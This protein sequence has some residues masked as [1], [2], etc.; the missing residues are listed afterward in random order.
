MTIREQLIQ[1]IEQAP[2]ALIEEILNFCLFVKQ[3]QQA[4]AT[5]QVISSEPQT[6]GILTFLEQV[7]EIQAQV[8][9]E[10]WDK[11]PHDGAINHDHYLYGAP[12]VDE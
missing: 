12:K 8:P 9:S 5:I 4:K 1:E 3:R 6:N 11:L 2:E 7:K 10:E